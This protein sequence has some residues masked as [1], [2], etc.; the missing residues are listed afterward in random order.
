MHNRFGLLS[1]LAL[2]FAAACGGGDDNGSTADAATGGFVDADTSVTI[3][4]APPADAAVLPDAA[5]SALGC[6]G[7]TLPTTVANPPIVISGTVQEGSTSGIQTMTQS[8][9]VS[10]HLVSDDSVLVEGDFTGDFSLTDPTDSTTPLDAYLK[11]TST[12]FVDTYVYPPY[13]IFESLAN[14]PIIMVSNDIYGLL[15]LLTG[16]TQ[17]MGN[18]VLI[19]AVVDCDQAA[20]EGAVVSITPSAGTIKYAG[21][22]GIPGQTDYPATQSSGI[23]YIFNVPPGT[24]TIGA[25]VGGMDLRDNAVDAFADSNT[26]L[27]VAP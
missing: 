17:A 22:N 21:S 23:A 13:A 20:V 8:A 24:Y 15:P 25:S 19:V 27:V 2:S 16:V 10:A 7:E 1:C 6:I 26:T 11:A 4:A 12:D 18:G 5:P 14:T 3:D 9:H